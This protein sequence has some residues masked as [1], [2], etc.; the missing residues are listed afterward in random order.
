MKIIKSNKSVYFLARVESESWV[1]PWPKN[2]N[3]F[4]RKKT[5]S[6]YITINW[7][8]W[9]DFYKRVQASNCDEIENYFVKC[10]IFFSSSSRLLQETKFQN[11]DEGKSEFTTTSHF[12][13]KWFF[14]LGRCFL[15]PSSKKMMGAL[16]QQFY[17]STT[18]NGKSMCSSQWAAW[19]PLQNCP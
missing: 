10:S 19:T 14:R 3:S 12:G 13:F 17:S 16:C 15:G 1:L 18:S 2:T 6:H 5:A 4:S 9:K 11:Y 7:K 8:K